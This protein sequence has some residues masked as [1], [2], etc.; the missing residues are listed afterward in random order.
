MLGD[1]ELDTK[2]KKRPETVFP[3][4]PKSEAHRIPRVIEVFNKADRTCFF[5]GVKGGVGTSTAV[6]ALTGVLANHGAVHFELSADPTAWCY[7]GKD[8]VDA[9][10]AGRYRRDLKTNKGTSLLMVDAGNG[11]HLED[12]SLA[13]SLSDC[14]VMVIDRSEISFGLA[15]KYLEAGAV[16]DILLVCRTFPGLGNGAEVCQGEFR[17]YGIGA[18]IGI[19]GSVDEERAILS[20]QRRGISPCGLSAELAAATGEIAAAILERLE[21][22]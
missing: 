1:R 16:P 11:S 12:I 13:F 4:E 5:F 18:I 15:K 7:Y 21:V 17:Q 19:P 2:E 10:S 22:K 8:Q 20:A 3:R 14:I 9:E 6:A